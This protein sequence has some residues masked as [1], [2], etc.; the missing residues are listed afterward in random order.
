LNLLHQE[1]EKAK[2]QLEQK[3]Q[4]LEKDKNT[5]DTSDVD[6]AQVKQKMEIAVMERVES[7]ITLEVTPLL[8]Y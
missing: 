6:L 8:Q 3:K 7:A 2:T 5:P 4:T 1:W